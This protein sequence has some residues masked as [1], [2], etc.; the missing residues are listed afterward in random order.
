MRN[1]PSA[2]D[3]N[4]Y[5]SHNVQLEPSAT[6]SNIIQFFNTNYRVSDLVTL[7]RECGWLDLSTE[8]ANIQM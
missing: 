6:L 2:G 7:K 3:L 8:V 1:T 4:T 5:P